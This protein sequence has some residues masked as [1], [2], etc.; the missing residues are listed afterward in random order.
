MSRPTRAL[1]HLDALRHNLART[2]ELAGGARVMVALKANAY[3]HGL[4]AV[5]EALPDADAFAVATVDEASELRAAGVS[6]PIVLLEGISAPGDLTLARELDLELVVHHRFQVEA[7]EADR[8]RPLNVWL[9]LDTGM[10]R[11]GVAPEEAGAL[12]ER[13]ARCETVRQPVNLMSHLA[14]A[15]ERDNPM[16]R[17]Q[18]ERFDKLTEGWPGQRS[19]ANSAGVMNWPETRYDWVRT[20]GMIYGLL[21]VS[22]KSGADHGLRPAMTLESRLIAVNR[23]ERGGRVGYGAT[24]TAP[25]DMPVGIVAIGYGDGYPRHAPSGTPVKVNGVIT[26]TVGR[27][28]MD[29]LAVDLRPVANARVGDRVVLWGEGLPAER[30][31]GAAGTISYELTSGLTDRVP[32]VFADAGAGA[33]AESSQ[34][35]T[36]SLSSP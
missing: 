23:V 33:S 21:T 34:S 28:S 5:A 36:R 3:G 10:H 13:L 2:R 27:V 32:L 35:K 12:R 11:L 8:G 22:H 29:L 1:I 26:E 19:L 9:K 17:E 6:R 14:C 30:V 18:R 25:E 7:L 16:T 4:G 15:E 31:A 20:G 24:W